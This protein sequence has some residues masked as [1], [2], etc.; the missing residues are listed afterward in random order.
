MKWPVL[1]WLLIILSAISSG[2]SVPTD[3]PAISLFNGYNTFYFSKKA[4]KQP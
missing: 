4:I 3:K 2:D 1:K